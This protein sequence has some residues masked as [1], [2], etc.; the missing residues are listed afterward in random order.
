MNKTA[1]S[2]DFCAG[3]RKNKKKR[4]KQASLQQ[5]MTSALNTVDQVKWQGVIPGAAL[6]MGSWQCCQR[7]GCVGRTLEH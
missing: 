1:R 2:F 7:K 4:H 6:H 5:R 3:D